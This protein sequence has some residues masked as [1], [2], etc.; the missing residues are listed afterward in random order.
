MLSKTQETEFDTDRYLE[1]IGLTFRPPKNED[2]LAQ[3]IEKHILSVA[4]ENLDIALGHPILL[5]TSHLY[6]KIVE[7]RRGGYCFELNGLFG[8]L[9]DQLGFDRYPVMARV[10]YR[11]P[12]ETPALTHTLNIVSINGRKFMADVGFG[13]TTARV[14][15][16]LEEGAVVCDVDGKVML[17]KSDPFG[18][19]LLRETPDGIQQQFST[20]TD[21]AYP[22]DLFVANHFVSTH[23]KSHFTR[24]AV[25]GMFTSD[26]RTGL[27]DRTLSIRKG[28]ETSTH[29]IE[30]AVEYSEILEERFGLYLAGREKEI[31]D[32]FS[33]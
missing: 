21:L 15:V 32:R 10:W 16:P 5:N 23:Q 17:E 2:G 14:P 1:R 29:Q 6:D 24:T 28:W 20:T 31:F 8:T 9:L 22:N 11:C 18:F 12:D 25:A 26:G 4:F 3:L 27:T 33:D 30:S 13:G 7:R 19:M